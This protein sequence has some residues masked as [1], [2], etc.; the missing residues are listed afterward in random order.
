VL[1]V[2]A[3]I[4]ASDLDRYAP[5][6]LSKPPGLFTQWRIRMLAAAPEACRRTLDRSGVA[7]TSATRRPLSGGCGYV[8]GVTPARSALALSGA[9][10][11]RCAV[12]AAYAAW[13]RHVVQPAAEKHLGSRVVAVRH[14]GTFSCRNVYGRTV[15]RRSQHATANAID[16]AGF[17]LADGR[18]VTLVEHWRDAG[19]SGRFLRSIRDGACGLFA[20]VLSP[21]ANPA[22]RDHFHFDVGPYDYCR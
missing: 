21:D 12:A 10:P 18:S 7:V 6:D 3:A 2:A 22:H 13:E 16:L 11:M 20:G 5:L 8:D 9:P 17:T 4:F 14:L 15:G 1:A 19:A